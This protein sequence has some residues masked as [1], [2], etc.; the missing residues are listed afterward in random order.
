MIFRA[1]TYTTKMTYNKSEEKTLDDAFSL[2]EK[3][4]CQEGEG[5]KVGLTEDFSFLDIVAT[6]VVATILN[7]GGHSRDSKLDDV[8][9]KKTRDS[10]D[11]S[12]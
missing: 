6:H 11:L 10:W 8:Y 1:D 7:H 4:H 3:F 9:L 2:D 12:N 5:G